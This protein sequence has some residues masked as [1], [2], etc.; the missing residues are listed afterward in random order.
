MKKIIVLIA[1]VIAPAVSF[2]QSIFDKL[3]NMEEV[4]SFI[5]N[6]DAFQLLQKFNPDMGGDNE[7][8]EIFKM[9]QNLKELKVFKTNNSGVSKT[10][11]TLV[12]STIKKG[13][14]T[15][16]MRF[17]DKGSKAKIYVKING[18]S[19]TV[20]EVLMYVSGVSEMTEGNAES[21]I[22]SLTGKIDINKLSKLA[23]TF[24][25]DGKEKSEK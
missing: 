14:L 20:S 24:T 4:S 2:G 25:K 9:V 21:V 10:M 16:L 6:K 17:K 23:D 13:K 5:I 18:N 7:A 3:E 1:L 8:L 19:D 22:V 12:A 15:E 11:E